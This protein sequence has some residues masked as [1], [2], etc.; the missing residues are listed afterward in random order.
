MNRITIDNNIIKY[1]SKFSS[2]DKDKSWTLDSNQVL[3]VGGINRMDGDDDSDLLLFI[4]NAQQK[5]FLNLTFEIEGIEEFRA[6]FEQNFEVEMFV[7]SNGFHDSEKVLYPKSMSEK[8]LYS[9]SWKKK[10]RNIFAIDHAA[11]D[12]ELADEV[13]EYIESQKADSENSEEP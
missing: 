13:I 2:H 11:A 1:E 4:D 8:K 7:W 10:L 9:K 6:F 3:L 5:Y 12:G